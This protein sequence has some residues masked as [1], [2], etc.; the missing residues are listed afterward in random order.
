MK[1]AFFEIE[2]WEKDYK[3]ADYR[4]RGLYWR[5]RSSLPRAIWPDK[6]KRADVWRGWPRL[7]LFVLRSP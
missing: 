4:D 2:D 6:K 1:I 7:H 5:T 3:S